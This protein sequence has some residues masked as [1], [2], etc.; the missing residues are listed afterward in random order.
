MT[1]TVKI[2]F[3]IKSSNESGPICIAG[4]HAALGNW[5]PGAVN[6]ELEDG[7]W[8]KTLDLPKNTW[9]EFKITDGTWDS[10]ASISETDGND[11]LRLFTEED[12]Q[13]QLQVEDWLSDESS[14]N[15][16]IQGK[17]DYL[18][19]RSYPG[20]RNREVIVWLPTA[21]LENP[22][23]RFP[24]LYAHD[25]QNMVDHR[26]A[27]LNGDW[28]ADETIEDMAK[29]KQIDPPIMVCI[30][31]TKDRLEEYNDTKLGRRYLEFIVKD[32][33]PFIDKHYRTKTSVEDTA[34]IGSSMGG[35]IS[36]LAVWYYPNVFGKAACLSPLFWGKTTVDVEAW[37][38][39]ENNPEH[40]LNAEIYMD[41]GTADLERKLMPGCIQMLRVL[42]ARGYEEK[43][44]LL[45]F[46]DEGAWHNEHA[47]AERLWRPIKFLYGK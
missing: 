47:W 26:T 16:T 41:N 35:L 43:K 1:K 36:F 40:K 6:M 20:L 24:V 38:M 11:N 18:G 39:V 27:F 21:Y 32:I 33:K 46:C 9:V 10:E 28:R 4:D 45:W 31:N 19:I 12:Q 29:N 34:V 7:I 22:S 5:A 44:N 25:G 42:K 30:Y 23:K 2:D 37:Q 13:I 14:V 3:E 15:N 17:V 8:K